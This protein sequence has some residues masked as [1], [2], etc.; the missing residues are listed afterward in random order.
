LALKS[1][2]IGKKKKKKMMD[3]DEPTN[4]P[5]KDGSMRF[6]GYA[7]EVGE[8]V[9]GL[10]PNVFVRLTYAVVALYAVGDA[11]H[12]AHVAGKNELDR[13]RALFK[14][15]REGG[16]T[17]IWQMLASVLI[18]PLIINR[19]CKLSKVALLARTVW[20][21]RTVQLASSGIGL[22]TI[23][24]IFAPIDHA[25]T[26]GM[27]RTYGPLMHRV[28]QFYFDESPLFLLDEAKQ[29]K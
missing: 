22:C 14:G 3:D 13:E 11:A 29:R 17:L 26:V 12:K 23:P 20:K 19:T 2:E 15:F 25:V 16:H 8:A 28:E 9:R 4:D 18:P 1:I 27:Q 24:I 10:A 5:F 6:V 21:P 7:N